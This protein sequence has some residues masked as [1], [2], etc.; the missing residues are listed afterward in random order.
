MVYHGNFEGHQVAVK[1]LIDVDWKSLAHELVIL[2][3]LKHDNIPKFFGIVLENNIIE[4]VFEY[5]EGKTLDEFAKDHFKEVEKVRIAKEICSAID[6][7][8]R[9][10]FIHRDL[11]IENIMINTDGK[12][13]LIDFDIA[14]V[15]TEQLSAVTRANGT[16]YYIAPEV[17]DGDDQDDEGNRISCVTHKVDVWAFG[18]IL[19]YLFS[20]HMPWTPKYKDSEP[21]IQDCIFKKKL[22]PI[23]D[24]IKNE[25]IIKIIAMTTIIEP[26]KRANISEI[27]EILDNM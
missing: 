27:K 22:Y 4:L 2:S 21:I 24:N 26:A 16:I 15:C 7:V 5:I 12:A 1:V 11:K 8:Y 20:G 23:P 17:F 9:N 10:N 14:K 18:C 6:C 13:Y 25:N 3:N 19:S